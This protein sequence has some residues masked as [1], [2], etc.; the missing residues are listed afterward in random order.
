MTKA[1]DYEKP[2]IRFCTLCPHQLTPLETKTP[3]YFIWICGCCDGAGF[4]PAKEK[5]K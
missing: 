2:G 3:G 1:K 4:C 5:A